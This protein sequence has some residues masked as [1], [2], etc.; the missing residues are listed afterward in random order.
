MSIGL[1]AGTDGIDSTDGP[2]ESDEIN[3]ISFGEL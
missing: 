2:D 1:D 3:G